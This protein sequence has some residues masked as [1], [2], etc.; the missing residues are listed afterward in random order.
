MKATSSLFPIKTIAKLNGHE[1][2]Y[3]KTKNI[4]G[5]F[6]EDFSVIKCF[7]WY[8]RNKTVMWHCVLY[9]NIH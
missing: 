3:N 4:D 6:F 5:R 1:V 8:K 7:I 2:T 9:Q